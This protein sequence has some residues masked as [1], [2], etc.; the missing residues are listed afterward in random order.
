MNDFVAALRTAVDLIL[1]FDAGLRDIVVLSLA[2]STGIPL[3]FGA[4]EQPR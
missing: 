1:G 3:W 2:V 4:K